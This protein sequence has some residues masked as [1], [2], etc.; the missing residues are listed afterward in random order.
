MFKLANVLRSWAGF[1]LLLAL[2]C[3]MLVAPFAS[4]QFTSILQEGWEKPVGTVFPWQTYGHWWAVSP[5]NPSLP[6]WDIEFNSIYHHHG[7][8]IEVTSVWCAGSLNSLEAGIDPY[9][10]NTYTHL[11]WGPFDIEAAAQYEDGEA[12]GSFWIWAD[13]DS[14]HASFY[15]G[16]RQGGYSSNLNDW[17]FMYMNEEGGTNQNWVQVS[18]DFDHVIAAPGDTISYIDEGILDNLWISLIFYSD[19]NPNPEHLG[20]FIDDIALASND[21]LYDFDYRGYEL[22][23][24]DDPDGDPYENLY[25]GTPVQMAVKWKSYSDL[26]SEI[27]D[28]VLYDGNN[29]VLSTITDQ[30]QGRSLAYSEPFPITFTPQ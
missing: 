4:A 18:F 29:N 15:F 7:N 22:I 23:D 2:M 21:G 1:T 30:W 24:P 19:S 11:Y 25:V 9:P 17:D 14:Q 12:Y 13:M 26:L 6:A 3:T 27:C 8:D 5:T 20:V 16:V 10:P 28:H